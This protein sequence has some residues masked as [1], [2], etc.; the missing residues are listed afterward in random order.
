MYKTRGEKG[1]LPYD[2]GHTKLVKRSVASGCIWQAVNK[3]CHHRVSEGLQQQTRRLKASG[4]PESLLVAV[5]EKCINTLIGKCKIK[6]KI[7]DKRPMV[8]L[9]YIHNFSHRIKKIAE[10]HDIRVALSAPFK[11]KGLCKNVNQLEDTAKRK[12]S[13]QV[14]HKRKLVEC[15][16][17]VVYKIPLTC[18]KSY[19][20][21][22][23][24]CLNERLREHKYAC[25]QLQAPGNLAAHCAGCSCEAVFDTTSILARSS[26]RT[27][28]E[29]IEAFHMASGRHGT[30]VSEPS[31]A[32]TPEEIEL[33]KKVPE[34][35]RENTTSHAN[36]A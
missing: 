18:G 22:T 25:G 1:I 5:A 11:L 21:Q 20:G 6:E 35:I 19:I 31:I 7:M 23:G 4:Y 24:R 3:S 36:S 9:P 30:C 2:F 34:Q 33:L 10:K 16:E 27:K 8:V 28:R 12:S 15:A 13:C 26:E 17:G 32:L 29:I 14:K